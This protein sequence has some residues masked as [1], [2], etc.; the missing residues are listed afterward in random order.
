MSFLDWV[1]DSHVT[2]ELGRVRYTSLVIIELVRANLK[3]RNHNVEFKN[4]LRC[5]DA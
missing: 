1:S 2:R 5:V 4:T 3:H